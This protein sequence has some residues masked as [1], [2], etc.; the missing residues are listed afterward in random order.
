MF[1]KYIVELL[2]KTKI[3]TFNTVIWLHS[4]EILLNIALRQIYISPY[5]YLVAEIGSVLLSFL[6]SANLNT[7]SFLTLTCNISCSY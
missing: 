6:A 1:K 5:N 4:F 3:T 2:R 7:L